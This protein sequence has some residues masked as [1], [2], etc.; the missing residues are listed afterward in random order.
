MRHHRVD[1]ARRN[2]IGQPGFA[3]LAEFFGIAAIRLRENPHAVAFRLQHSGDNGNAKAGMVYI[4]VARNIDK[5]HIIPTAL[6]C[7]LL[8]NR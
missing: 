8:R 1:V 2:E 5:I 7:I 6:P 4:G 3:E